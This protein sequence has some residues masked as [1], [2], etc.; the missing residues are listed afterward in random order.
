MAPKLGGPSANHI[1][2]RTLWLPTEHSARGQ[3]VSLLDGSHRP[4]M[5]VR[6]AEIDAA[7]AP[8][9][10]LLAERAA[11]VEVAS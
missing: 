8:L 9:R 4:A 11:G 2:A 6:Y 5:V 1:A 3:C 10:A 7:V